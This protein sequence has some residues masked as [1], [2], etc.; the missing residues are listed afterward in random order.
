[1]FY[2]GDGSIR[3]AIITI[4]VIKKSVALATHTLIFTQQLLHVSLISTKPQKGLRFDV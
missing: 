3:V 2:Q 4:A 1:M